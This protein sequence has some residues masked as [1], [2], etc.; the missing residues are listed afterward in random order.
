MARSF[1]DDGRMGKSFG[2]GIVDIT[3]E[4]EWDCSGVRILISCSI[5]MLWTGLSVRIVTR[6]SSFYRNRR[7][8]V[9]VPSGKLYT[10]LFDAGFNV[11]TPIPIFSSVAR[12]SSSGGRFINLFPA[13]SRFHK[14]FSKVERILSFS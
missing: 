12:D 2:R 14:P 4:N 9:S 8:S 1:G 11:S 10:E 13:V 3:C 6:P 5:L 7:D